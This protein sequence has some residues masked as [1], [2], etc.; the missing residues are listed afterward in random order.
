[1]KTTSTPNFADDGLSLD[2]LKVGESGF[3]G[4]INQLTTAIAQFD[5]HLAD[6]LME[7]G[8]IPGEPLQVLHK[9][10]FGG[11]PIAVRIGQST[12]ALRRFEAALISVLPHPQ[13]I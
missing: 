12:F 13:E 9:G 6:R 2:Q 7:I 4:K 11:E 10:F 3:V 1:V 5:H 8:F